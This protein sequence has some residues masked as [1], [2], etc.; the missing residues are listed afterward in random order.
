MATLERRP[1]VGWGLRGEAEAMD[2]E[3][4]PAHSEHEERQKR[5][6]AGNLNRSP[7][8]DSVGSKKSCSEPMTIRGDS[9]IRRGVHAKAEA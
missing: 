4:R 3:K 7:R 8:R 6:D 5:G 1:R 9:T 2:E